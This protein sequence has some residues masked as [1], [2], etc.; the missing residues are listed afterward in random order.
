MHRTTN[1]TKHT[2]RKITHQLR[3]AIPI[4]VGITVALALSL[5]GESL[6]LHKTVLTVSL[7][8]AVWYFDLLAALCGGY[9]TARLA[10]RSPVKQALVAGG[11]LAALVM[12]TTYSSGS[13]WWQLP[14]TGFSVASA[15]FV[16]AVLNQWH[17][18]MQTPGKTNAA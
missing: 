9:V 1:K 6:L 11:L 14:P 2:M 3:S 17:G 4:G 15:M 7:S 16:G 8:K 5:A 13:P 12:F 18:H 10:A